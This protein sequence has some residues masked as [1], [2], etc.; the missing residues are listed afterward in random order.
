MSGRLLLY[1]STG[2]SGRLVVAETLRCG[3]T[4]ILA[5]RNRRA[6]VE[7]SRNTG[8][9][10]RVAPLHDP[11]AL[12]SILADVHAALL[13]AGPFSSTS[14]PFVN[15]CLRTNTH[16]LDLTGEIPVIEELATRH[17]EAVARDL[18]VM[19][20]AG[21]DA[22]PSDCLAAHVARRLPGSIRLDLG[23]TG[24]QYASPGSAKTLM[25]H[26]GEG[27]RI[28]R[29][30]AIRRVDAWQL[31]REFDFGEGPRLALNVGWGDISCAYYTTGI[32]NIAVYF[33]DNSMLRVMLNASRAAG[34]M[35]GI[36]VV[37][38]TLKTWVDFGDQ[39]AQRGLPGPAP[40]TIVAEAEDGAGRVAIARLRTPEAYQFTAT[41]AAAVCARVLEGDFESG[42]QTA[43]RVYGPDFILGLP[44]VSR[45]DVL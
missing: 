16:Y 22:V 38:A 1:G 24:L 14:R 27:V 18:L 25:E 7:Q 6:L 2:L 42:F 39:T 30:G 44:G 9:E 26:A 36:P 8:L 41:V 35:L 23:F 45:E 29:D 10:Y 20:C 19:P 17:A 37:Q 15:A 5:G 31:R 33:E 43:A 40:M 32:P 28:R 21:F 4:P 13:I 11:S 12:D 3:L 34:P